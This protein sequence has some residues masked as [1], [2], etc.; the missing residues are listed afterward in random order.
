MKSST[1]SALALASSA[2]GSK[3][4]IRQTNTTTTAT[5]TTTTPTATEPCAIVSST[6][7][8]QIGA[9]ATPTVEASIA[10][11][12]L[13]SVPIDKDGALKFIDELKPY[14]EW[15]SDT[16][17]KKNP[18]ADYGYPPT[19]IWASIDEVRENL[20]ADEYANEY[21]WQADLY[22]KLFGPAHDGHFV[23]Y[24]DAL[25]AAVEWQRPFA[26]V[27]ISEE[28][29]DGSA[30]VIK[31]YDDI[32][33]GVESPSTV[34][35]ING[36]DAA[37][38]IE[39]WIGQAGGNQ[40]V[41][42]A[43]NSM[44]FEKAFVAENKNQGYFQTGGRVRYIYPGNVTSFTFENGTVLDLPNQARLKG[45]WRTVVDGTSF[46]NK[47]CSGATTNSASTESTTTD[48]TTD[49]TAAEA[50]GVPVTGYP[51]PVIV[52][53][54]SSISGYYLNQTGFE[55]VAV[56]VML[57]F[58]PSDPVEFQQVAQDF[59]AAAIQAGK[60][61][62]VVDVQA[63]GGGYI[64]LGY[65]GF[66][67]LF[68]DIVQ[69]GLGRWRQH[70]GFAAVSKVFSE[71]S[72]G[73]DPNTASADVIEA[74]ESVFNWQ[75]DLNETNENFSS[76]EDKFGPHTWGGDTYTN[77]MQWNFSDPLS[78]SNSSFGFGTDITGYRSRSNFTRPFGGPENIVL[79]LDGYCA[80]TC[81]LF[82]EF[83]RSNAGVKSIAMGGRPSKE[84]LIQGVG[85]VKGSQSYGFA[86]VHA[87]A[88]QALSFTNDSAVTAT[89]NTY[90]EYVRDRSTAASLNVKDQILAGNI[91]DGTPAQFVVEESDC[92]LWWTAP[93][94]TDVS[95]L[96]KA[97]AAAAFKGASCAYG[98]IDY[99][100]SNATTA[101]RAA[102]G[103]RSFGKPR[104]S[105]PKIGTT[106]PPLRKRDALQ[107]SAVF[108]A[109]QFMKVV[110]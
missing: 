53:S 7:S 5:T 86:D 54:D 89:L 75:Y 1:V 96:W 98:A 4:D 72:A 6:W 95:E 81:T 57:S 67:Q 100:A 41:D 103:A 45:N 22:V 48:E 56:L 105:L 102:P 50:V 64:F 66:R 36:V 47:F 85:G 93:M 25:S 99:P 61:K 87:Q 19:D 82:S 24:P 79:L 62:L 2:S 14:V 109:N 40:D 38:Y 30:P 34:T 35:L 88:Q 42:A 106:A 60:T 91:E 9:T 104:I 73:F 101:R 49:T 59:Y 108:M 27:S 12:C 37:T 26:L 52:S 15:Q 17:F 70:A 31:V 11:E 107:K 110:D 55:D 58:S 46:F 76:Y 39:N 23:V 63:N 94:V 16:I 68:P 83:L 20:V 84:G 10:Y 90:T 13:N 78:T 28:G 43:Y 21:A 80:S 18:P 29:P 44:F 33:N 92:R 32:L 3:L 65:D 51:S 69:E 8:A 74:Y 77:L 97:A 71:I